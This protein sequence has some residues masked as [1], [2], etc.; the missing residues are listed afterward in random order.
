M[1]IFFF[2]FFDL[3]LTFLQRVNQW[4]INLHGLLSRRGPAVQNADPAEAGPRGLHNGDLGAN[5]A[6]N[7]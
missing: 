4:F 5:D 1:R 3:F 6:V 7:G 2:E